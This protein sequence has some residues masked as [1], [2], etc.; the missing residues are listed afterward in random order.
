MKRYSIAG[1]RVFCTG[2]SAAQAG[3]A[4]IMIQVALMFPMTV[5]RSEGA[6]KAND[7]VHAAKACLISKSPRCIAAVRLPRIE[8]RFHAASGLAGYLDVASRL[9]DFLAA[10]AL[11][12]ASK[13]KA[14]RL[15]AETKKLIAHSVAARQAGT[16]IEE[17]KID[18]AAPILASILKEASDP[19][20]IALYK[21]LDG[22]ARDAEQAGV[23]DWLWHEIR[24]IT[25]PAVPAVVLLLLLFLVRSA[26]GWMR[27][28]W[29]T[30]FKIEDVSDESKLGVSDLIMSELL[31]LKKETRASTAGLLLLKA[32][33]IPKYPGFT[34]SQQQDSLVAGLEGSDLTIGTVNVGSTAKVAVG[35]W[36]WCFSD[37]RQIIC[38]VVVH[39]E[40]LRV[41]LTAR[42]PDLSVLREKSCLSWLWASWCLPQ[43]QF[44]ASAMAPL[45]GEGDVPRQIAEE[46]VVKML[47]ALS[48][49][50]V[51]DGESADDIRIGLKQLRSY[52]SSE[53]QD[54]VSGEV[55]EL[56]TE[57]LKR[58]VARFKS[59]RR[60]DP[61]YVDAYVYEGVALDLLEDHENAIERF[62]YARKLLEEQ[63]GRIAQGKRGS[64]EDRIEL[65]R[66]LKIVQYNEA[67]AHLRSLYSKD[68]IDKCV[69]VLK[70][71]LESDPDPK[72]DPIIALAYATKADAIAC[73]TL[74]PV[75]FFKSEVVPILLDNGASHDFD[76]GFEFLPDGEK[77][78]IARAIEYKLVVEESVRLVTRITEKLSVALNELK[79]KPLPKNW[80]EHAV[81]QLEWGIAN[82]LGDL[83][84]YA[85]EAW[86]QRGR[87][88][89]TPFIE[90]FLDIALDHLKKCEFLFPPGVEI[91]SNLGTLYILR[92]QDGDLDEAR[93]VLTKVTKLNPNYEYAYFRIAQAYVDEKRFEEASA[94]VQ[95]Y[96]STGR[97]VNIRSFGD[98][99]GRINREL[100]GIAT[101]PV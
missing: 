85:Y 90:K 79:A 78:N 41:Q 39:Q 6:R 34:S 35:L 72:S 30:Q 3:L 12:G 69:E 86:V 26:H 95:Q 71:L 37:S 27:K 92:G 61:R 38:K 67:V 70:G 74:H 77:D 19:R 87:L 98:L 93:A 24:K 81:L 54:A 80:D 101:K 15:R 83:Y 58:A 94:T 56:P 25:T 65:E 64:K 11:E 75:E 42:Y 99:V 16:L 51:A 10:P 66:R 49:D 21:Q 32:T 52:V 36:R 62:Q 45:D 43:I 100:A 2:G 4:A 60:S 53:A 29:G 13:A 96:R 28:N 59:A 82:A 68:G 23:V 47:Y 55:K 5:V 22:Q 1:H 50:N 97:A 91:L 20:S 7:L 31:S 84:L 76:E 33:V 73:W 40:H 17:R 89:K 8:Q 14:L 46:V 57:H 9:E 44:T 48:K 63:S 18:Q 88:P